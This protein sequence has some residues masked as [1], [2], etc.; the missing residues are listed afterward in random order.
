MIKIDTLHLINI[1]LNAIRLNIFG[2]SAINSKM[3]LKFEK[4]FPMICIA[5]PEESSID[6]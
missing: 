3:N 5:S 4:S 2:F 1:P 6:V